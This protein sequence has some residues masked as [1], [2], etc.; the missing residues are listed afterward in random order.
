MTIPKVKFSELYI[1]YNTVRT[2]RF[3]SVDTKTNEPIF[4]S[5]EYQEYKV[6]KEFTPKDKNM[7]YLW[8]NI[9]YAMMFDYNCLRNE[10]IKKL[11]NLCLFV[12]SKIKKGDIDIVF[13]DFVNEVF[14]LID[15]LTIEEIKMI[16]DADRISS[17]PLYEKLIAMRTPRIFIDLYNYALEKQYS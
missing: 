17:G 16:Q 5:S 11:T 2:Q 12:E 15:S 6:I 4:T 3:L 13:Y 8:G 9:A 10:K 1:K 7:Y 14:P